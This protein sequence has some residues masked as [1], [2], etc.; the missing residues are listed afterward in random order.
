M[1]SARFI[2]GLGFVAALLAPLASSAATKNVDIP[3][4]Y[5][6]PQRVTITP[7]SA[8]HWTNSSNDRHSITSMDS[9]KDQFTSSDMCPGR[10]LF[11]RNDCLGPGETY[12][13]TFTRAGT[14]DYFCKVH[15]TQGSYPSC[16]MCGRVTVRKRSATIAPTIP[17]SPSP[18]STAS[19][20]SPTPTIT[21]GVVT[22]P[23]STVAAA[24]PGNESS[25]STLL[26]IAALA[27]ALLGGT[28]IVVY[29]TMIRR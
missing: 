2:A 13:H 21:D 26:A 28:G 27:V 22:S 10:G 6:T 9:S 19:S 4:R 18:S 17:G 1:R 23:T 11:G 3:G 16:G 20:P 15:G 5:F 14:Y 12:E 25:T 8:V 7:G 24:P 29:R